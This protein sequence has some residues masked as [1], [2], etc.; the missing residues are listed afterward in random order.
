MS[1]NNKQPDKSDQAKRLEE[2]RQRL[3]EAMRRDVKVYNKIV[4]GERPDG[5]K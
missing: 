3:T 2:Q 4:K 5:K 1:D